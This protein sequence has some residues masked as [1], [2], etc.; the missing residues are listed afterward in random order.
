[1]GGTDRGGFEASRGQACLWWRIQKQAMSRGSIFDREFEIAQFRVRYGC[2]EILVLLRREGRKKAGVSAVL[3]RGPN[4]VSQTATA[5]RN[6]RERVKS[7]APNAVV[8]VFTQESP[9]IEVE[10]SLKGED[11]VRV[12]SHIGSERAIP[13]TFFATT[14]RPSLHKRWTWGCIMPK[15]ASISQPGKPTD[16]A[17]VRS[18]NGTLRAECLDVHW[19]GSLTGQRDHRSLETRISRESSSHAQ[20]LLYRKKGTVHHSDPTITFH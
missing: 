4:T 7:T 20:Q 15:C 11:V 14:R 19:F 1:L 13:K 10:P 17:Y 3:R 16:N 6:R 12:L 18:F 5:A 2:R 9:A 8:D